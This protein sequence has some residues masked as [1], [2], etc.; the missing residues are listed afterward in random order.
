M[1]EE[2][3]SRADGMRQQSAGKA[4]SGSAAPRESAPQTRGVRKK[5]KGGVTFLGVL[6]TLILVGILTVAIF[7]WIFM[8]WVNGSLK[9]KTEVYIN[10]FENSV[11]T[12]L[13]YQD[14][15][16]GE[17]SMYQTLFMEGEDRIWV[18]FNDIPKN[19][20]NAAVAIEDKRFYEHKGVDWKGTIRA[21][22]FTLGPGNSLQ[23]GSTITQQLIK[24]L[25]KDDETT[26][27]RKVTE[28]YR[29]L[30]METRYDKDEI[31]E[32]YLNEI[33][34]GRS[35]YGVEAA[36]LRYFGKYVRELDLA[37][38]ASLIS[39]T[40]NPSRYGPLEGEWARKQ[41]RGRQLDVLER[42]LEQGM[43]S[44]A[45]YNK[46]KNEEIVFTNGF[47]NLG[48]Y[49]REHLDEV[50]EET[51]QEEKPVSTA[52]NSYFTDA[53]IDDVA[54]ALVKEFGLTENRY[55][56]KDGIEHVTSAYSQA[57]NMVYGNGY[58]IYTT[59]NNKYQ[60]ITERIFE[61]VAN[62]PYTTGDG[63][64]LQGAI[65]I[66]DPFTGYVVAM[67]G[68]IG[69]KVADRGWNWATSER[70]C[71]SAIKPISTYA[72]ALDNGTI[73]AASTIDDY[74]VMVL[75][76]SP[77]PKNDHGGFRGLSTVR[78]AIVSSLN[79]CAVRVCM[80]YGVWNAYD[81]MINK[82]GFT[83]LTAEDSQQVG[84]MALGG[85]Q[86][87]VTTEEMAAAYG[88]FVNEG[89][90]TA[91]RTFVRVEDANGRVVL[92]NEAK[93]N[94]AI[95]P[96][97]AAIM[98]S[99]LQQVITG[100]TGGN[101]YFQGMHIAG[102]T[103]TTNS[104]K[105]RYFCGYTPYYTAACWVGYKSNSVVSSG[106]VNPAAALWKMVM[107]EIHADLPDKD[108]FSTSGLTTVTVC[109]DSGMLATEA[110]QADP[111]GSRV[112]T[113]T[114]AADNRPTEYCTM[115]QGYGVLNYVRDDEMF[116]DYN[117]TAADDEYVMHT[118][119]YA[120]WGEELW[121]GGFVIDGG[122]ATVAGDGSGYVIEGNGTVTPA[123]PE[124]GETGG[125]EG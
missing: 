117:I 124:Q 1:S 20:R 44:E 74:P 5:K 125:T 72:P 61:D 79:T 48:N 86:Y 88:M 22:V 85:F 19:L 105:D 33:Y 41:N 66:V 120:P 25:T 58:K 57:I 60:K 103:G 14:A 100:G 24:N 50:T 81:F 95:K 64:Q 59:Q 107:S 84:N 51:A 71:G 96:T 78:T 67:V 37:E 55:T 68:G 35:C 76:R 29:A 101:A 69:P 73:T 93:S 83:T 53:V 12:E 110:C 52:W 16:T 91:P 31:L 4:R 45:E 82:L 38:C 115:H 27:K 109:S 42:M 92:E 34:L 89:I 112:R 70:P 2:R 36:S 63:E 21:V 94:V 30:E 23:G 116:A 47:T 43:I 65:T 18:S 106:G 80:Q 10:E 87:G 8:R 17:W 3:R 90:Y 123:E 104:Q 6:G 108:F 28:I 97:T 56:D 75:N 11:S 7:A 111:R 54:R 49:V 9:G 26:V 46:A 62:A 119:T 118:A 99:M 15:D 122:G 32:A 121:G 39:I 113:E 98:N 114:C 77:Y 102:K 40:N 13:Y